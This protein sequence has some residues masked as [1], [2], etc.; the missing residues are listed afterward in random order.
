[1]TNASV[2]ARPAP[3]PGPAELKLRSARSRESD[4]R[5]LPKRRHRAPLDEA[6]AAVAFSPTRQPIPAEFR[7]P[8][9][10]PRQRGEALLEG[11]SHAGLGA[12]MIDQDDLAARPRDAREFV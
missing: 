9:E 3:S 1:M 2:R 5:E 12:E 11:A 8:A 10:V 4:Q 7:P 6:H